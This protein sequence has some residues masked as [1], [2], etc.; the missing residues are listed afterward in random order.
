MFGLCNLVNDLVKI[1]FIPS[2]QGLFH[3]ESRVS[4]TPFTKKRMKGMVIT[5]LIIRNFFTFK[6]KSYHIY[7]ILRL[8]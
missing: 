6:V 7:A 2:L 5:F 8:F 3:K 4:S 1:L